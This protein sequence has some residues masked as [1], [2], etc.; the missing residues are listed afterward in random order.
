M[1]RIAVSFP[2]KR[3]SLSPLLQVVVMGHIAGSLLENVPVFRLLVKVAVTRRIAVSLP[4]RR[5]MGSALMGMPR[6]TTILLR[7][8]GHFR[9]PNF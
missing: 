3:T 4:G 6:I 9:I 8:Y 2:W 1:G 5:L 7:N